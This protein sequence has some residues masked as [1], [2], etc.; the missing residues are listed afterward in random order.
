MPVRP[1]LC[2]VVS[3]SALAGASGALFAR[4][5]LLDDALIHVRS[6]E[7]LLQGQV[8]TVDSSPVFLLLTAGGLALGGSFYVTKLLSLASY[9]ALVGLVLVQA[10][11]D[12]HPV[13]RALLFGFGALILSPFGV[14]WLTDGME[15]SLAV[16]AAVA[17]A[18]TLEDDGRRSLRSAAYASLCVAVRPE[19]AGLVVVV[20]IGQL[21]RGRPR[22][23]IGALAGAL[24]ALAAIDAVFG[25][26]WSDAAVAKLRHAYT[27][28]EF[29]VLLASL[30]AGAGIL[31]VGLFA[32]WL[33]LIFLAVPLVRNRQAWP[34]LL[35]ALSLPL[36]LG[37]IALRGQAVEGIR[38]LLPFLAFSL[39]CLV[40]CLRYR[41]KPPIAP[42]AVAAVLALIVIGG[43]L[44]DGPAFAR[45]TRQQADSL[46]AMRTRDWTP[47]RGHTGVAWDVGYL[48]YFTGTPICDVQGLINGAGFARLPITDRLK[49]CAEVAE[50]AF[51]DLA[52][53]RILATALDT[54][55]WRLCDRFDFGHR[56]ASLSVYLI[57]SPS[58]AHEPLC[59]GA[60]PRVDGEAS[61]HL[62]AR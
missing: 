50:F 41:D 17:L 51:V 8:S 42:R 6:A 49:R 14:K 62:S 40:L 54:T 27:G 60:A 9:I 15:T 21:L 31:G 7:L 53:F 24:A 61:L 28:E 16:L 5:F 57:V 20:A 13:I 22:L 32:A 44:V 56:K 45:I 26:V 25:G 34:P 33:G 58:L 11:R 47:L 55:G 36:V 37:V 12:P 18:G 59:N 19:L 4:H 48:A 2:A 38:P 52:R 10:C 1:I 35:G 43:W 23:A 3:L 46:E 39:A 30:A 29:V